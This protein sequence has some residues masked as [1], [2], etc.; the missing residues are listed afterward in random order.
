MYVVYV[1]SVLWE[2]NPVFWYVWLNILA[3]MSFQTDTADGR[4]HGREGKQDYHLC[5]DK[6]AM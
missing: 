4:N 2:R 5:G 3:L 6:E 1:L